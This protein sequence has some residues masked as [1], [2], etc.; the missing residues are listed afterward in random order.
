MISFTTQL[1]QQEV[2]FTQVDEILTHP[3]LSQIEKITLL[4]NWLYDI[5]QLSTAAEENLTSNRD[6]ED[7]SQQSIKKALLKLKKTP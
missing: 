6:K 2:T 5:Q 1:N 4:E 7:N 3:K